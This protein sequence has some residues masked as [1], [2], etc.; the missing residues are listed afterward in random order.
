M[1][2]YNARQ[3]INLIRAVICVRDKPLS[4]YRGGGGYHFLKNAN[5]FFFNLS[6]LQTIYFAATAFASNYFWCVSSKIVMYYPFY[7]ENLRMV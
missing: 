6:M 2:L 1:A 7:K 4:F 5:I 3:R